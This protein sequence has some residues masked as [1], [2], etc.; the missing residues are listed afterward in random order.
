MNNYDTMRE[1]I[2]KMQRYAAQRPTDHAEL[3]NRLQQVR[4]ELER[5]SA[6]TSKAK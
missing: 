2:L 3:L 5:L 1:D 4:A 6:A